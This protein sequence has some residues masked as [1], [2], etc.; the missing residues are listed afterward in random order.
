MQVSTAAIGALIFTPM[1]DLIKTIKLQG[2]ISVF[3]KAYAKGDIV[4]PDTYKAELEKNDKKE[5]PETTGE[6][7]PH[8]QKHAQEGGNNEKK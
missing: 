7:K 3:L 4:L 1:G 6:Q 8:E 2:V 5:K